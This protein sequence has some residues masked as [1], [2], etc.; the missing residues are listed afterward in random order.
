M[1]FILNPLTNYVIQVEFKYLP[2][3]KELFYCGLIPDKKKDTMWGS[4]EN[5]CYYD[6]ETN[7]GINPNNKGNPKLPN[8]N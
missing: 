6:Q 2:N 1:S 3:L 4:E 5:L 8:N 7:F